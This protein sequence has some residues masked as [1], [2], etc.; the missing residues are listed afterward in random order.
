MRVRWNWYPV[1]NYVENCLLE[2][3]HFW[4][5]VENYTKCVAYISQIRTEHTNFVKGQK[6]CD[7]V[8]V[9]SSYDDNVHERA[10]VQN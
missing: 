9:E 10:I 8:E 2:W 3:R 1:E 5:H 6:L 4:S 7:K